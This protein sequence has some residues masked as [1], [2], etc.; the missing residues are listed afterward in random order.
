MD[1]SQYP[2][3]PPQPQWQQP[4]AQQYPPQPGYPPQPPQ[5]GYVPQAGYPSQPPQ[6][7]HAAQ[8]P[9]P[10]PP[11]K[12]RVWLIALIAVVSACCLVTTASLGLV[13]Y[14]GSLKQAASAHVKAADA[15]FA[16]VP[17]RL[18]TLKQQLDSL[19][20]KSK[21][22]AAGTERVRTDGGKQLD[23]ISADIAAARAEIEKLSESQTKTAYLDGL[24]EAD[25][26]VASMR[27]LLS[28]VGNV[29]GVAQK[30]VEGLAKYSEGRDA[31]N[32]AISANNGRNWSTA[33]TKAKQAT[34]AY[35][36][37]ERLFNEGARI[38]KS[39]GLADAARWVAKCREQSELVREQAAN[40]G[41]GRISAYNRSVDRV[42]ALTSEIDKMKQPAII[43]DPNW[44]R[45]ALDK[46][47]AGTVKHMEAAAK[48][49]D[50]A[51]SLLEAGKY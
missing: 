30:T 20:P 39:A 21:S 40:G 50:D 4:P 38:D 26:G 14:V 1:D 48:S 12:R 37:A 44:G 11:K 33:E 9:Q 42:N 8:P 31:V 41:A 10:R 6:P 22:I 25:A 47:E 19:D 51:H 46:L 3:Q 7:G 23:A 29:G 45:D 34:A 18:D 35:L 2:P 15:H 13:A 16:N 49:L 32:A 17:K 28:Y 36:V 43:A 27:G 5:P 24:K